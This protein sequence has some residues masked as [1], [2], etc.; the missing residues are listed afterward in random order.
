LTQ[1]DYRQLRL[2]TAAVSLD[3]IQFEL[4]TQVSQSE[5]KFDRG[6]KLDFAV[7]VENYI[8]EQKQVV[9]RST[10]DS[11]IHFEVVTPGSIDATDAF[12]NGSIVKVVTSP[13]V[14]LP[15]ASPDRMGA[16]GQLLRVLVEIVDGKPKLSIHP[17]P[18]P[19]REQRG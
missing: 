2:P 17:E 18:L 15:A 19:S 3:G 14:S 16:V 9:H 10:S 12:Q 6:E 4:R 1:T 13:W 11:N 7:V 8:N 5:L